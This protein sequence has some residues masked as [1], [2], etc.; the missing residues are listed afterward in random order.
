M[1]FRAK[2]TYKAKP[3]SREGDKEGGLVNKSLKGVRFLDTS[4]G[5]FTKG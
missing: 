2:G 1:T 4:S 3:L 5:E